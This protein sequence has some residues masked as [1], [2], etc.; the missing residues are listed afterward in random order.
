[1]HIQVQSPG[2]GMP[3]H[4]SSRQQSRC[5]WL[6][7]SFR[8][9]NTGHP[10]VTEGVRVRNMGVCSDCYV[11]IWERAPKVL[12]HFSGVLVP[13]PG[14]NC[15]SV[16]HLSGSFHVTTSTPVTQSSLLADDF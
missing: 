5:R 8:R 13:L 14:G 6:E 11:G 4:F 7:K 15:Y 2:A 3:W 16:C 9:R 12:K 1:M 10:V